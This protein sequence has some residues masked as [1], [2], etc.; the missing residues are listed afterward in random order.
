MRASSNPG[1]FRRVF[2]TVVSMT[3]LS[4]LALLYP[5]LAKDELG[6]HQASLF[7]TPEA[8]V[9]LGFGSIVGLFTGRQF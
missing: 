9:T 4:L 2:F 3:L 5:A 1:A 8:V 6:P 7:N